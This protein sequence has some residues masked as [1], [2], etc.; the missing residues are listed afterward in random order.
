MHI[1]S[2]SFSHGAVVTTTPFQSHETVIRT[3]NIPGI[4]SYRLGSIQGMMHSGGGIGCAE[5]TTI[6]R[7]RERR[8]AGTIVMAGTGEGG[9]KDDAPAILVNSCTGKVCHYMVSDIYSYT[10]LQGL[11]SISRILDKLYII[12][13][14]LKI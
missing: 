11:F 1:W 6:E 5:Q 10:L 12:V 4:V 7:R 14:V 2:T 9:N 13:F 8:R 3:M